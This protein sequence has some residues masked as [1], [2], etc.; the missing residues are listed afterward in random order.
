MH[1]TG[2]LKTTLWRT[3]AFLI[4]GTGLNLLVARETFSPVK[5]LLIAPIFFLVMY[6]IGVLRAKKR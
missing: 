5:V 2:I 3:L 1:T 6:A 4:L